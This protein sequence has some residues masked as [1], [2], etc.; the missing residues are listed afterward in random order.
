[1]IKVGGTGTTG[2]ILWQRKI[3]CHYSVLETLCLTACLVPSLPAASP[4]GGKW[5]PTRAALQ[6]EQRTVLSL[7]LVDVFLRP[8]LLLPGPNCPA[9]CWFEA[10]SMI[11]FSPKH[12]PEIWKF[13]KLCSPLHD[14]GSPGLIWT[15]GMRISQLEPAPNTTQGL[16]QFVVTTSTP[17]WFLNPDNPLTTSHCMSSSKKH[18]LALQGQ[19]WRSGDHQLTATSCGAG[20]PRHL[21]KLCAE[22]AALLLR[23]APSQEQ[24]CMA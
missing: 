14:P 21:G 17:M 15:K 16:L 3:S 12:N 6:F 24:S 7:G 20:A 1:M 2:M 18:L 4:R 22:Q 10:F 11:L 5:A 23:A 8:N 19:L 13:F 9:P